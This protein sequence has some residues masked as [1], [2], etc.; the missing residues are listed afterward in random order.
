MDE[1]SLLRRARTN[2]PDRTPNEVA[3]GRTALVNLIETQG[4]VTPRKVVDTNTASTLTSTRHRRQ[5][6]A[7]A[8]FSVLGAAA[9]VIALVVINL[10]GIPGW[11]GGA[12][13]AA[14]SVLKSAAAAT[15]NFSDPGVAP[16]Q[17]LLVKTRAMYLTEG[18]PT[19]DVENFRQDLYI[20]AN[21][22]D[23]WVWVRFPDTTPSGTVEAGPSQT[24]RFKG[25]LTENGSAYGWGYY[26]GTKVNTDYAALPRDPQQLLTKIYEFNGTTG[27]SPDGEALV[28]IADLLR[29]GTVPADLRAAL[30]S[31]A[32]AIPAVTITEEQATL[33]GRTGVA[34]GRD[35]GASNIRQDII[36]DPSTGQFIGERQVVLADTGNMPAGTIRGS[37]S[38]TSTVV[39]AAP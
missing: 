9:M 22:K 14:A 12:E 27:P 33:D 23:D 10:V 17:F 21:R 18:S 35:E 13:P 34:I 39:D 36:I 38:V 15:L 32:A 29:T 5:V 6:T 37:A 25:G 7:W 2:I 1:I 11:Q 16:G 20:P 4:P 30:Y 31:A 19:G 26:D 28:W 3:R 8:G 24:A